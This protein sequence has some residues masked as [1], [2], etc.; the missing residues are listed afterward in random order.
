MKLSALAFLAALAP[1]PGLADTSLASQLTGQHAVYNLALSK[2]RTHDITGATGQMSFNVVDGCTGW[3]TTQH[4]TL[5][6][7]NVDGS[8]T[9]SVSDYVTWE[10]K[11]GKTLSFSLSESD[12]G[13]KVIIDSAGVATHIGPDNSG[14]IRYTTPADTV[15]KVPA[16]TLFPMQHTEAL[17]AAGRAGRMFISPLLFD[18]TTTDGAQATFVTV[19]GHHAAQKTK[20]PSLD[21]EASTD[22]DIAFFERKN[23]D[24][25][26]DFRT[27]MQYYENGVA[28][29]LVLDF[30]DFVMTGKLNALSIPPSFCP[31]SKAP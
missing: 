20:W 30:G 24:E 8:L 26:P 16:G 13:G 2:L 25:T 17:L 18:G 21:D 23:D 31:A 3:A 1:L 4:M 28:T 22:V 11:D 12:N 19:L 9:K 14:V 7:R 29:G 6:V 10:S 15:L 27:S 5:I